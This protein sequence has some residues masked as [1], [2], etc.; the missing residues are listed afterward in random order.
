MPIQVPAKTTPYAPK[1]GPD[2]TLSVCSIRVTLVI[3]GCHLH[4][5]GGVTVR[6]T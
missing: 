3:I 6:Y 4:P 5:Q 1:K 2:M